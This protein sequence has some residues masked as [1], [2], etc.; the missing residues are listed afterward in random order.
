MTM[1]KLLHATTKMIAVTSVTAREREREREREGRNM[2]ERRDIF[3]D[4]QF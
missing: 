4:Q 2:Y 1:L 3:L